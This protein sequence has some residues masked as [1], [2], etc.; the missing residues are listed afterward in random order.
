MFLGELELDIGAYWQVR[1]DLG[2]LWQ[3][4]QAANWDLRL[5]ALIAWLLVA[6]WLA[7]DHGSSQRR[8]EG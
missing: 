8:A 4:Q 6:I 7:K 2:K 3:R 1:T 5:Q